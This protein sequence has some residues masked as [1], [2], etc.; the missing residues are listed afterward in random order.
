MAD[1][2][3]NPYGKAPDELSRIVDDVEAAEPLLRRVADHEVRTT[4]PLDEV[5]TAILRHVEA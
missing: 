5:V 3:S 1:R 2:T 4:I